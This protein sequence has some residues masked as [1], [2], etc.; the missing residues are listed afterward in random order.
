MST[1]STRMLL[2]GLI[3]ASI[4]TLMSASQAFALQRPTQPIAI[5]QSYPTS[6]QMQGAG[7]DTALNWAGYVSTSGNYTSV[8]G[9]WIVPTVTQ[10]AE[11]V[12]DATW[13]GI[14]G[15][16][17]NDL[18]QA[19][20][21]AIPDSNGSLAYEAWYETLPQDSVTVPLS[22][23]AGDSVSVSITEVSTDLWQIA[24]DDA[25]TGKTYTTDVRYDSSQSSADWI[26]EMPVEVNGVVSLDNFGEVN[27][28]SGYAIQNGQ[29]VTIASSGAKALTMDNAEGQPTATPSTLGATGSSFSVLRTDAASTPLALGRNGQSVFAVP[30]T[31]YAYAS[32]GGYGGNY[33]YSGNGY[34]V[35]MHHHMG[36]YSIT[37]QL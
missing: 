35:R 6:P 25:T 30:Q 4:T 3:A 37:V 32:S 10:S 26:E 23:S 28:T 8:S 7:D 31:S 34:T 1:I 5:Q 2:L 13:V 36:G 22:I 16:A 17:T 24:F 11:N 14:G 21:E 18:I 33:S 20:T 19:G 12:A 9:S 29:V 15:V 27:F